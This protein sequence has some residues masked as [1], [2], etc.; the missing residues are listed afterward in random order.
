MTAPNQAAAQPDLFANWQRLSDWT[1]AH[2]A[3]ILTA[4]GIGI[5]IALALIGLRGLIRRILGGAQATGWRQ[6]AERVVSRT[7]LFFIVMVAA[8]LVSE[9]TL[10]PHRVSGTIDFL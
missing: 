2:Y 9:Q 3:E 1:A 4:L 10:L 8:K 6:V 5:L 7:Y